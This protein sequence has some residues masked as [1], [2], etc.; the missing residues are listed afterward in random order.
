MLVS[1]A[2]STLGKVNHNLQGAEKARWQKAVRRLGVEAGG[3]SRQEPSYLYAS[4]VLRGSS[5]F[6]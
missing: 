1:A 6:R 3:L 2:S 4:D 5:M